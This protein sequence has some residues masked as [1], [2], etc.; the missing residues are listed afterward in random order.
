MILHGHI[1]NKGR[2]SPLFV[3]KGINNMLHIRLIAYVFS[4]IGNVM[5]ITQKIHVVKAQQRIDL[6]P[7][8][9][10]G[11]VRMLCIGFIT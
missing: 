11:Q 9:A 10:G 7:V 2:L 5:V 8:P 3:F 6:I 1:K 4:H